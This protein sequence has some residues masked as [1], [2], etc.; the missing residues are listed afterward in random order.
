MRNLTQGESYVF[1]MANNKAVIT[2]G[3]D[4]A[5]NA[6]TTITS[7]AAITGDLKIGDTPSGLYNL[8]ISESAFPAMLIEATETAFVRLGVK[9]NVDEEA[10][11][12]WHDDKDF[13]FGPM[14]QK[15]TAGPD[16]A[17]TLTSDKLVG[18]GTTNPSAPLH[19]AKT[20]V[21]EIAVFENTSTNSTTSDGIKIKC[22]PNGS[23][24][25][26]IKFIAFKHNNNAWAGEVKG[27]G[28]SYVTFVG[29]MSDISDIKLK[30]DIKLTK[31]GLD[32]IL[33]L[34]V[35]DFKYKK[36]G[37]DQ[38]GVIAQQV[39]QI[40]PELVEKPATEEECYTVSYTKFGPLAIKAIQD[41]QKIIDSLEN[42]LAAL[43]NKI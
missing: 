35:V 22:G 7:N 21:N 11:L 34:E 3:T 20:V 29:N 42:R 40:F 30:K 18:I 17:M 14:S 5:H 23:S 26:S 41:Q 8:H 28:T 2:S 43:E 15:N 25:T 36:G 10:Y 27:S 19:V 12:G 1:A 4:N 33:K 6:T 39:E 24:G 38:V 32:D 13:R 37:G 9:T 16:P 31:Y